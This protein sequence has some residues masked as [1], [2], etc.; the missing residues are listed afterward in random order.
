MKKTILAA[1]A[2]LG[3]FGFMLA[4]AQA[5][6]LTAVSK[7]TQVT[8]Y[9]DRALVVR[10][11]AVDLTEGP[12][13]VAFE[14]L[15]S[16]L[17]E[18]SL[19]AEGQGASRV[20]IN[21][22]ELKKKF[23]TEEADPNAARISAEL[24]KLQNDMQELLLKQQA[25][26]RQKGFIDSISNFSSMQISKDIMTK[27]PTPV[28]WAGISQYLLEA[29]GANNVQT[30]ALTQTI[31]DKNKEVEAKQKE[32]N[33]SWSGHNIE[34]KTVRVNL[35]AKAKAAF[36]LRLYYQIPQASWTISYDAKVTQDTKTCALISYGN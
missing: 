12:N 34:K 3:T 30:L 2:A 15:P 1:F 28:E 32:L 20:T 19:R 33:D 24:E 36:T 6:E 27:S 31:K 4:G 21:G 8:V 22:V 35:E 7:I 23:G 25:V 17:I 10:E 9:Q 5:A 26:S 11:C 29:Y 16:A 14:N 13:T 18:D